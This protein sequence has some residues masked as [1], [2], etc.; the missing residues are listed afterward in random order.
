MALALAYSAP[1]HATHVTIVKPPELS[2]EQVQAAFQD[3]KIDMGD[4]VDIGF[5]RFGRLRQTPCLRS[6]F[7]RTQTPRSVMGTR[8][9]G[10]TTTVLGPAGSSV[11]FSQSH[12]VR[13][14]GNTVAVAPI[15]R[16]D[17]PPPGT[18]IIGKARF[19]PRAWG[20][21]AEGP[22]EEGPQAADLPEDELDGALRNLLFN[23]EYGNIIVRLPDDIRA[24][25]TISGTVP[26]RT[27]RRYGHA[28]AEQCRA[29][30]RLRD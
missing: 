10:V 26:R 1:A 6:K 4:A 23:T 8:H 12:M 25:D 2:W 9:S 30:E 29:V 20:T 7:A 11:T 5:R 15:I 21:A 3:G 24:G 19:C 18:T 13:A 28:A 22:A 16:I 17:P 14:V 27:E